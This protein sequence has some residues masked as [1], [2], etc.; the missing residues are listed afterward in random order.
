VVG[1][2][3]IG[4]SVMSMSASCLNWWYMLGS[5]FL[6]C[7]A[8][9]DRRLLIQAMSRN[10]PPCGLPRPSRTSRMILRATWSRVRSSGGRREFLSPCVYFQPSSSLSAVELL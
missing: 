4:T 9:A 2:T 7:S 6:M 10:T 8:P 1:P 5:F 3:S